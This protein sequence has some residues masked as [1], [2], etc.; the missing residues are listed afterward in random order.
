MATLVT[1]SPAQHAILNHISGP[2]S[3]GRY[4]V[5]TGG[6]L[7]HDFADHPRVRVPL[8]SGNYSTAAGRYQMLG[9]TWDYAARELGLKDFSP[10]NQD[11]AALWLADNLYKRH[12]GRSLEEDYIKGAANWDILA[13]VWPSMAHRRERTEKTAQPRPLSQ[14]SGLINPPEL[15]TLLHPAKPTSN[16]LEPAADSLSPA[17]AINTGALQLGALQALLPQHQFEPIDYDPWKLAPHLEPIHHDP[18]NPPGTAGDS[19][20]E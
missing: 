3:A 2:E 17:P 5:I 8:R 6:Q 9:S 13:P 12:T 15:E 11:R 1:L 18:F 19:N 14:F 4:N 16:S 20:A 7:F 10:E